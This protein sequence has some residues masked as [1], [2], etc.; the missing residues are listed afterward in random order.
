MY[1]STYAYT[2]IHTCYAS[3]LPL[4]YIPSPL[5]M[6]SETISWAHKLSCFSVLPIVSSNYVV[7]H[8]STCW[9]GFRQSTFFP[10]PWVC[11]LLIHWNWTCCHSSKLLPEEV[12]QAHL[13]D[14][15]HPSYIGNQQPAPQHDARG[16]LEIEKQ[17]TWYIIGCSNDRYSQWEL[18]QGMTVSP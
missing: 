2:A 8:D 18:G 4:S 12:S 5:L 17:K 13:S 11:V 6:K 10:V 16:P 14:M 1:T 9:R 7:C 3:T 15:L